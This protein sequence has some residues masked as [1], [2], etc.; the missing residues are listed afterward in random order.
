LFLQVID[1]R[2]VQACSS[3]MWTIRQ[4]VRCS[5]RLTNQS[6]TPGCMHSPCLRL[7]DTV[8]R[9]SWLYHSHYHESGRSLRTREL[10]HRCLAISG[11]KDVFSTGLLEHDEVCYD[12]I[13]FLC[14]SRT[15]RSGAVECIRREIDVLSN[16]SQRIPALHDHM[17]LYVITR[18]TLTIAFMSSLD[19]LCVSC[20]DLDRVKDPE[21]YTAHACI[22]L[23]KRHSDLKPSI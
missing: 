21:L 4:P 20:C 1:C 22:A 10:R 17:V 6:S 7:H 14:S 11:S 3:V 23:E 13:Y 18:E 2:F 5:R 8:S 9:Y 15:A 19:F 16:S 12:A